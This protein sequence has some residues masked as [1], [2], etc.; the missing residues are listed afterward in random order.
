MVVLFM[1]TGNE[2]SICRHNKV[3]AN[4]VFDGGPWQSLLKWQVAVASW[5]WRKNRIDKENKILNKRE[6]FYKL[7]GNMRVVR[8]VGER[9]HHKP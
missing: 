6:E 5:L 1:E 9:R 3:E 7:R 4:R 8:E 2:F